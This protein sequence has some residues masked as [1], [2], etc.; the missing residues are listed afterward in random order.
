MAYCDRALFV[1]HLSCNALFIKTKGGYML[2]K[3][4]R[5]RKGRF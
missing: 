3:G 4:E 1:L 2:W 5:I